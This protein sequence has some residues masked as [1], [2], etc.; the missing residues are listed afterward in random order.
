MTTNGQFPFEE[1]PE[2]AFLNILWFLEPEEVARI[3][4]TSKAFHQHAN[5]PVLWERFCT[6]FGGIAP[7]RKD[8]EENS[9]AGRAQKPSAGEIAFKYAVV[10]LRS[11]TPQITGCTTESAEYGRIIVGSKVRLGKHRPVAGNAN[12]NSEMDQFVGKIGVVNRLS[13]VDGE[14]CPGVRVVIVGE[15]DENPWFWR[16]RDLKLISRK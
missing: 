6:A 14:G 2:T 15:K 12:W 1:L 11:T 8:M 4:A 3:G 16:V 5:S 10:E 13:G 7:L 9:P